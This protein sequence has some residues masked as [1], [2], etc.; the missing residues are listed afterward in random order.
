[1]GFTEYF[2]PSP[3]DPAPLAV[4]VSR[5]VRFEEID[6]MGIVWHGRYVSYF[7]DGRVA[8]GDRYGLGYRDFIRRGV[9]A[10]LVRL[11]IDYH[12]PLYFDDTME[13]TACMHWN[14]AMR[15][16]YSFRIEG[17]ES[18]LVARG[19]S[20]QLLTDGDNNLLLSPPDWIEEFKEQWRR[21]EL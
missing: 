6:L 4:T 21:G 17:P 12:A 18:R 5:R 10:P 11:H 1:M 7:E 8:L 13:I 14:E 20:M 15:L 16:D 19:Y 9:R 3:G 2:P